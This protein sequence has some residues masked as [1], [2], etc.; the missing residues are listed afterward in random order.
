MNDY[1][2]SHD[3]LTLLVIIKNLTYLQCP[4]SG[5]ILTRCAFADNCN[6]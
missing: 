4:Y 5:H 1:T 3:V 6:K 2:D